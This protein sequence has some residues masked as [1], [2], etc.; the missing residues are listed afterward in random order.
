MPAL[1]GLLW[2]ISY[3]LIGEVVIH[4]SGLPISSGVVGMLLL[5]ATLALLRRVPASL[6]AAAQPLIALLAMLIMPGVVGVFFMLDELAGEWLAVLTALLL[7]TLLSVMTT[8]W[9]LKRLIG[10]P[11][12]R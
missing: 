7:G 11:N 3:W 2:L 5:C 6:A 1:N 9:L 4:F 8:L 12:A 10:R